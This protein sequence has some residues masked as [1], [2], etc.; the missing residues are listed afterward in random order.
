[1]SRQKTPIT[2]AVRVLRQHRVSIEHHPYEYLESGGT[3]QFAR[4]MGVDEHL[5][6][7]TLIMEDE[8]RNPMIVL[9]HGDCEVSTKSLARQIGVKAVRP[10]DPGVADKHSGY[11][12]GGTSP[13]GTRREMP[14]YC[15]ASVLT[16][17]KIY[18]N[19]GKSGYIISMRPG[20]MA[21]ILKPI[22]VEAIQ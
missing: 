17:E 2:Q 6:I 13:F 19:G 3:A 10:C 16:L 14:V 21:K 15:E 1:M 5:V 9:M 20:E 7:K 12:V 8:H 18:I 4:E 11:Q 22:P